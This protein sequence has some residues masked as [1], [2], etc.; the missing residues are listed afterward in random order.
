MPVDVLEMGD[1]DVRRDLISWLCARQQTKN[2]SFTSIVMTISPSM[3]QTTARIG[4]RP[5]NL[6]RIL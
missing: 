6:F 4:Y 2:R 5:A 1:R 3:F